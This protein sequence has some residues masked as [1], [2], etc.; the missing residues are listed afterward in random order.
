MH[1][2]NVAQKDKLE[3]FEN[4][5]RFKM[6]RLSFGCL[7][8][9]VL[10]SSSFGAAFAPMQKVDSRRRSAFQLSMAPKFDGEKW[11]PTSPDEEPLAG[12]GT[13]KTLLLH[14][15]KPFFNR[16]FQSDDYDQAVLKFMAGDK[17]SRD[18]AQGNMDKYLANPNDWAY[19]RFEEEK[20][21]IK[22]DYVTLRTKDIA[23]TVTWGSFITFLIGR[24]VY[25][26]VTGIYFWG[27]LYGEW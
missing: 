23:L 17:C 7:L 8:V 15:P 22:Y 18:V 9:A 12:Y 3:V 6:S 26:I 25:S 4:C 14:G 5:H 21:G 10:A 1:K 20:K 13:T 19:N 2:I 11:V 27:F 16:I 24:L